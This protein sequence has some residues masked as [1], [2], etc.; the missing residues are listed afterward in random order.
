MTHEEVE[1]CIA[2][3]EQAVA[4]LENASTPEEI[5]AA[6]NI[7]DAFLAKYDATTIGLN[8][9]PE[10]FNKV[11]SLII[12]SIDRQMELLFGPVVD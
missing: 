2:E 7:Q 6:V 12:S 1:Q 9:T 3:L 11:K 4:A 5:E 8:A 10:Q